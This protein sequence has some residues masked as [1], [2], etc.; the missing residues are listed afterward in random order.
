MAESDGNSGFTG[1]DAA[2]GQAVRLAVFYTVLFG[3]IGVNMP[4]WPL[5]LTARG[6]DAREI[7]MVLSLGLAMKV[8]TNQLAG[9]VADRTGRRRPIMMALAF[10]AT[11][12]YGSFWFGHSYGV[13]AVMSVMFFAFWSPLLPLNENLTMMSV[14]RHGLNYGRIR[15]WGSVGF[16]A[17]SSI[18]GVVLSGRSPDLVYVMVVSL[19]GMTFLC[20]MVLPDLRV[21]RTETRGLTALRVLADRRFVVFLIASALIQASHSAY[22]AFASLHWKGQ[23]HGEGVIGLLWAEGVLAE[24]VLFIFAA[25]A[26]ARVGPLGLLLLGGLA[27]VVRWGLM[28]FVEALPLIAVLQLLHAFSFGA[29]HLG[30]MYFIS[31]RIDARLSATAQGLYSSAVMGIA[32]STATLVSGYLYDASGGLV[33][34]AMAG[35]SFFGLVVCIALMQSCAKE[36]TRESET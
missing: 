17:A 5:W 22:Y 29:A 8:I 32:L 2:R 16:I 1:Q 6:L 3:A 24:I 34:L 27:G 18:A 10:G 35:M 30:A 36:K 33:F 26:L 14:K 19:I 28:P 13:L 21:A 23:G 11:L 9:H 7:G 15:L 12:A 25:Q 20:T 31:E 4:F